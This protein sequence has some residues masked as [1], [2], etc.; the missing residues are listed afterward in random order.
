MIKLD[1][2]VNENKRQNAGRYDSTHDRIN[3]LFTID[4]KCRDIFAKIIEVTEDVEEVPS[5]PRIT[6]A[7]S[8][9]FR[10]KFLWHVPELI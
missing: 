8:M 1:A 2:C 5:R 6:R 9:T 4:V 10:I 3:F 7:T